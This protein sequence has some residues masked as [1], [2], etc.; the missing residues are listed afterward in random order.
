MKHQVLSPLEDH[1]PAV[2]AF[3]AAYPD[4]PPTD[5]FEPGESEGKILAR[6]VAL[7]ELG[8]IKAVQTFPYLFPYYLQEQLL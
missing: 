5:V 3:W 6:T 4:G 8:D 2:A 7:E 1:D